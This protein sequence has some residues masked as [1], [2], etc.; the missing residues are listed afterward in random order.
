[1]GINNII[2]EKDEIHIWTIDLSEFVNNER[3][4]FN[5]L[6]VDEQITSKKFMFHKDYVNYVLRKAIQRKIIS[7]YLNVM[8][9]EVLYT[10]NPYEKP[11]LQELF[12]N[13]S[14][15]NNLFV[16]AISMEL[17][18]GIDVERINNSI[19]YDN[20][21]EAFATKEE[22]DLFQ[23]NEFSSQEKRAL[24]YSLWSSKEAYVKNLG[25]GLHYPLKQINL[26]NEILSSKL[27]KKNCF[28]YKNYKFINLNLSDE[29]TVVLCT[30]D[31]NSRLK[32][33]K[34]RNIGVEIWKEANI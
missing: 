6:S 34:L 8:P 4:L 5:L 18:V 15:S 10:F 32:L 2:L 28:K 1:M 12:F 7:S 3:D 30:K 16:L 17:N 24:F 29:Y 26:L 25:M 21:L 14:N 13:T 22:V 31:I 27:Q 20:V 23:N 19:D 33:V 9:C 11:L